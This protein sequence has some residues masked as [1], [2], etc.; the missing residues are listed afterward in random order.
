MTPATLLA[1]LLPLWLALRRLRAPAAPLPRAPRRPAA[2]AAHLAR[3]RRA[4][5]RW[6]SPSTPARPR[7]GLYGFDRA[8][9]DILKREQVPATIFVSGRWVE[10][11]PDA[12]AELAGD[13]LIEFGDHSYD[14]PHMTQLPAARVGEEIDQTEAALAR[15]GKHASPFGRRS[16]TGTGASSSVVRGRTCRPCT[17]DVVSGDPSAQDDHRRHDP[18]RRRARA[19]RIDHH[20]SHQRPRLEDARGAAGDPERAARAR[21]PL[22][23]ALGADAGRGPAGDRAGAGAARPSRRSGAACPRPRAAVP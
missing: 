13:P 2:V 1:S 9:F 15:Y 16:A 12:M 3:R 20:L 17:W 7:R 5:R 6:P 10:T 22:R 19:R 18:R 8:V 21:V 23:P 11:H 14:H 4:S